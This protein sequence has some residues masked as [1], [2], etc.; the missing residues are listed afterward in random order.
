M[1]RAGKTS[2]EMLI[3]RL[4]PDNVL[5]KIRGDFM[6][7]SYFL[8][9]AAAFAASVSAMAQDFQGGD[10]KTGIDWKEPPKATSD[11]VTTPP[12]SDAIVLFDGQN[13]DA[14]EGAAWNVA[15]NVLTVN[16]GSGDIRT[17]QK[18]G[19][20][21]LHLEFATPAPRTDENGNPVDFGQGRGNSGLFFMDHYEV[22][23]LDN[24]D[25][26]TY[27]DG[28]CGSI[29]KQVA[30]QVNVCK[31]PG[32]W[33]SFD[34]I[35]HRPIFTVTDGQ[36]SEVVRPATITVIQNGVLVI[37]NW[38]IKGDTY[39]NIPAHY[40]LHGDKEPIHLQDH[41]NPLQFRNIWVREIP[42]STIVPL[43]SKLQHYE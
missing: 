12:P 42:D 24:F 35:F 38:A 33:Q 34:V 26:T 4:I 31:A 30:P 16:P 20:V 1:V 40:N 32:E 2:R 25:N 18:F 15:D 37:D 22:Q 7:L 17:K 13:L 8:S 10:Y 14:W 6:K 36:I 3:C 41:G 5:L 28:Q 11:A 27:F 43:Q 9:L 39:Y 19:S 21:Q 29:Y 23:I